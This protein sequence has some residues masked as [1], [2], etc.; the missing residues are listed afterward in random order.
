MLV[1]TRSEVEQLLTLPLLLENVRLGAAAYSSGGATVPP[2]IRIEVGEARESL[3][4]PGFLPG[5]PALGAKVVS[6]FVPNQELGLPATTGVLLLLDPTTGHPDALIDGGHVTEVRTAAMT[7]IAHEHLARPGAATLAIIGAGDQARV[8]L[9]L[10]TEALPLAEVRVWSRT[11]ERVDRLLEERRARN[12]GL[13]LVAAGSAEAAVRGADVVIA[14][15]T[16]SEPVLEDG[17]VSPGT[18]V[19]GVGS[20]TANAAEL[21]PET[22]ARAARVAVDTRAGTLG[23]GDLA[24]PLAAG[25]LDEGA[26]CALG[27]LVLGRAGGRGGDDEVTVFKSVGFAAVDLTVAVAL[28]RLAAERGVGREIP[29]LG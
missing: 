12:P 5:L 4:M 23:C 7:L 24:R 16:A 22:I 11:R 17:W 15:T 1:L 28:R 14:A 19:C 20:H 8:H 25:R 9:D 13:S 21:P 27:E 2:R 6:A 10:F 26:V 29:L 3:F 18:L